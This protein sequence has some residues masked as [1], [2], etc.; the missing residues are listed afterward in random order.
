MEPFPGTL[1]IVGRGNY[2]S[3]IWKGYS[4]L[5]VFENTE[6][7]WGDFFSV[8]PSFLHCW[9]VGRHNYVSLP[10]Q[11]FILFVVVHVLLFVCGLTR[12]LHADPIG[13]CRYMD[14]FT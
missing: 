10:L 7:R 9:A 2:N 13:V 6:V 1:P 4:L 8:L 5:T 3:A 14:I 11:L 12:G